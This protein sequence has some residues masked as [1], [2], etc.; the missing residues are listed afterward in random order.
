MRNK[1]Q[2]ILKQIKDVQPDANIDIVDQ[3]FNF[4]IKNS[5]EF[6]K[7]K[8]DRLLEQII[9]DTD[10]YSL[11]PIQPAVLSLMILNPLLNEKPQLLAQIKKTFDNN[12]YLMQKAYQLAYDK[13]KD[14]N[15]H[16][17]NLFDHTLQTTLLVSEAKIN[18]LGICA[19]LLKHVVDEAAVPVNDLKNGFNSEIIKIL[20]NVNKLKTLTRINNET[21]LDNLRQMFLA[22]A[23]DLRS[24]IIKMASLIDL[25]KNIEEIKP[26]QR[27]RVAVESMQIYAPIADIIGSWRFK[28]QLEDFAFKY[29]NYSEYKKIEK[30]FNV[31][32]K[33][34]REKYIE[35]IK[36]E[37]F[38][39][40]KKNNINCYI[41]GRFKHFYSIYKKMNEKQ[42]TFNE[43]YDVFAL[44]II[45]DNTDDCYRL[46][47]IIHKLWKPKPRRFKDYIALPKNNQ[48]RSLHTTVFGPNKRMTEFQIRTKEMNDEAQYGVAAHWYYKNIKEDTP[49]WIKRL[50][51]EKKKNIDDNEFWENIKT[52]FLIN[53]IFVF[54]PKGDIISLPKGSTPID[55]AYQIHSQIGNRCIAA[56]VNERKVPLNYELK[57]ED[58]VEI[59]ID[60]NQT[61]PREE[62]LDFAVTQ[63]AKKNIRYH[64]AK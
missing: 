35:I 1:I 26:E 10:N 45:V 11:R 41:D 30:K 14:V 23:Q 60:K 52:Q 62:W 12:F 44:R 18:P 22:M 42:K 38:K 46:L 59:L 13:L 28:W 19:S 32:E 6:E 25:I 27:Q 5:L 33:K 56:I 64:I 49:N 16:N 17:R 61:H 7:T 51:H 8:R 57:N 40:A 24:V 36:K 50:L 29:L 58:K 55:F 9:K 34:N 31:D 15:L 37:I 54:T 53:K 48:Y 43:I 47:G 2:Q 20:T 63:L 4:V 39:E 3:A 21:S